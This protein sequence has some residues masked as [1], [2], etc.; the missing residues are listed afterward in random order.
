MTNSAPA[1]TPGAPDAPTLIGTARVGRR[2]GSV[3][4]RLQ[5]GDVAVLDHSDIDVPTAQAMV[6]AGVAAVINAAPMISGRYP[7]AGPE[8]LARAGVLLVEQVGAETMGRIRDARTV[9]IGDGVVLVGGEEVGRGRELGLDELRDE[10]RQAR[11]GLGAH[12]DTFTENAA[13]FLRREHDLVLNGIGLPRLTT[14]ID[15]RPVVVVARAGDH[16]AE[17]SAVHRFIREQ[18]PVLIT[19]DKAADDILDAGLAPHIVVVSSDDPAVVPSMDGLRAADDVVVC[20]ERGGRPQMLESLAKLGADPLRCET[21]ATPEDVALLLADAGHA[22]LVVGVGVHADLEELLDHRRAA[23]ASTYLTRL[24]LGH[25]L[26]D[27]SSIP[28]LYSGRTQ[29]WHVVLV[30]L[31]GWV[32]LA[33]ALAVTPVG[34]D[35]YVALGDQLSSFADTLQGL[36]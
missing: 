36:F 3:V 1:G 21:G 29:T 28:Q 23:L 18:N 4:D 12:L 17:L 14:E 8:V 7:S 22:R 34:Q 9:R 35:W 2:A 30:L 5:S 13:E 16:E 10:M 15:G 24:K 31:A 11:S 32:A 6:D 19:V 25:T 20:V 27:A 33:A 26:V